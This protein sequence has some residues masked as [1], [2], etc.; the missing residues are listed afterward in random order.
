[1]NPQRKNDSKSHNNLKQPHPITLTW[2]HP[3]CRWVEGF[4]A[5]SPNC[6][7]PLPPLWL[8]SSAG[9]WAAV[10]E[11]PS[12]GWMARS[13]WS[14]S[15]WTARCCPHPWRKNIYFLWTFVLEQ[16]ERGSAA[17]K[18]LTS[19]DIMEK[20]AIK[21]LYH[22][23]IYYSSKCC[24]YLIQRVL[25]DPTSYIQIVQSL[26]YR[27]PF[28]IAHYRFKIDY[29]HRSTMVAILRCTIY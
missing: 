24:L 20:W 7:R 19:W 27:W 25:I 15:R 16:G 9:V 17:S 2:A 4:A 22:I 1:M 12:A 6:S 18:V 5:W 23:S 3:G 28:S 13:E 21:Q 26:H 11:A 14:P 8:R 10:G 29:I